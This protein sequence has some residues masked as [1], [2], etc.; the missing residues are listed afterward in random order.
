[1]FTCHRSA[2]RWTD[3][4]VGAHFVA[5]TRRLTAS[6]GRFAL[7]VLGAT[8]GTFIFARVLSCDR[9]TSDQASVLIDGTLT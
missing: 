6:L 2:V 1:M 5:A 8:V 3:T 7:T 9:G 4:D